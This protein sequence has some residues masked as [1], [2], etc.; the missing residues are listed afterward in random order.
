MRVTDDL[1][2]K[3]LQI[4]NLHKISIPM[5]PIMLA[6]VVLKY[7]SKLPYQINLN[8]AKPMQNISQSGSIG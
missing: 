5:T 1:H 6:K 3:K 8:L 7:F 2:K 4:Q